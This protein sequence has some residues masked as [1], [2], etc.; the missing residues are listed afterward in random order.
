MKLMPLQ[1]SQSS[2][3]SNQAKSKNSYVNNNLAPL[4]A[5]TVSFRGNTVY[6]KTNLSDINNNKFP[7]DLH[8]NLDQVYETF[9]KQQSYHRFEKFPFTLGELLAKRMNYL[10]LTENG[11]CGSISSGSDGRNINVMELDNTKK[12]EKSYEV[13]WTKEFEELQ[14][15]FEGGKNRLFGASDSM[16]EIKK[17][18][19]EI[20]KKQHW[21]K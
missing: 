20:L 6:L 9:E 8:L 17:G 2:M 3:I 13:N 15:F 12:I 19:P 14:E 16:E 7:D 1:I 4:K 11:F 5:D 10:G 21:I 18:L